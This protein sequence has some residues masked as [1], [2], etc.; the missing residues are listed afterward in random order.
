MSRRTE[1]WTPKYEEFGTRF[2]R[3]LLLIGT[4]NKDGFL[5]DETGERR[6]LPMRVGAVDVAGI[7]REREQLWA[8]GAHRFRRRGEVEWEGAYQL[9]KGEH[10]KFKLTDI[11]D[12]AVNDWLSRDG[13]D[14]DVGEPRGAGVVR[15][16]E[17]LQSALRIESGRQ[18]KS[19]EMRIAKILTRFGYER[20]TYWVNG[21]AT[22]G[23]RCRNVVYA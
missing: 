18:T 1:E 17:I 15:V 9:A 22:K 13:M 20:D 10:A 3:R 6:W 23:W 7:R 14:G 21:R 11:W 8:E 19:D 4:G 12:D 16:S 2:A 5:D